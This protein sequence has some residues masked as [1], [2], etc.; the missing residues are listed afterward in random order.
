LDAWEERLDE[1]CGSGE[2][3][4]A[5][6]C[7]C[8]GEQRLEQLPDDTERELGLVLAGPSAEHPHALAARDRTCFGEQA[9]LPDPRAPLDH[10]HPPFSCPSGR[11]RLVQRRELPVAFEQRPRRPRPGAEV[12]HR[13]PVGRRHRQLP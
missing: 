10:H 2:K 11:R 6:V 13:L 3:F 5:L 4:G 8:I 9:R 12:V 7:G 1:G